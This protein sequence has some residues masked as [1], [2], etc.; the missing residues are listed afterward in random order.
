MT[1][2]SLFHY[3][4]S[5]IFIQPG[6]IRHGLA[7]RRIFFLSFSSLGRGGGVSDHLLGGRGASG[8]RLVFGGRGRGAHRG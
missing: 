2:V 1:P 6:A 3:H 8:R 5:L 4:L 7:T